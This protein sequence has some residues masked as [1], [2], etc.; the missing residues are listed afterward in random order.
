VYTILDDER[1]RYCGSV[2]GYNA[3]GY[4]ISQYRT[5]W[6]RPKTHRQDIETRIVYH[7]RDPSVIRGVSPIYTRGTRDIDQ[8]VIFTNW[9]SFFHVLFI[10]EHSSHEQ[11]TSHGH[12][13]HHPRNKLVVPEKARTMRGSG[14]DRDRILCGS[15]QSLVCTHKDDVPKHPQSHGIRSCVLG[16]HVPG[17]NDFG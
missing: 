13:E 14:V 15:A 7:H 10:N 5:I 17:A 12:V 8:K 4:L 16:A 3:S 11:C 9:K 1:W 6:H 2:Y